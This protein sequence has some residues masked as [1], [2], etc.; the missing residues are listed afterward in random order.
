LQAGAKPML[1]PL[2][3]T[4]TAGK[5]AR[6]MSA[7]PSADALSTT[8]TS[9]ARVAAPPGSERRHAASRSRVFHDT[10]AIVRSGALM[11]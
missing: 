4:R 2:S 10:I 1:P 8:T 7:L 5:D 11:A 9:I 6:T 3:I